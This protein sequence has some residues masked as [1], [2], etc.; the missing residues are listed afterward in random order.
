MSDQHAAEDSSLEQIEDDAWGDP[1]RGATYLVTSV[2]QL[3]RRPIGALTAEDL[4]V[5]IAQHVG[6]DVLIPRALTRL[7]RDPSI[8]GDYYPGDVL[9]AMLK[10]PVPY[11]STHP[12]Q[13]ARLYA[14]ATSIA[15][16]DAELADD[17]DEFRARTQRISE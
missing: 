5:L 4:R 1:P 15:E 9:V 3:R 7:E 13:L 8:E 6:L 2:H 17:I 11:W 16:P 12:D 10:V 14:V